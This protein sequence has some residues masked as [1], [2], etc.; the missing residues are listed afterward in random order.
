MSSISHRLVNPLLLI[1]RDIEIE[2]APTANVVN[3]EAHN[4][5]GTDLQPA[6]HLL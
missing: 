5:D 3:P 6:T 2:I 4:G 1:Y